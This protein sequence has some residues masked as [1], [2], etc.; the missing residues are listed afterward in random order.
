MT[1]TLAWDGC[2]NV[3]D[4]GGL[5]LGDSGETAYRVVVRS[6]SVRTL[7]DAGWEA[8]AGYGV[9]RIL[10]LRWPAELARDPARDLDVEVVHVSLFGADRDGSYADKYDAY[11][12]ASADPVDYYRW[13]YLEVLDE[14]RPGFATALTA[15]ADADGTAVVHCTGGKDRTGL[16]CALALRLAGVSAAE[17]VADWALSE[18]VWVERDAAWVAAAPDER[19]RKRRRTF[20]LAPAQ[21]MADVLAELERRHGGARAY[22]EDAGVEPA[23]LDRLAARLRGATS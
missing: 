7:S 21:A 15:L 10:D 9:R 18:A 23:A 5:P 8:L 4:L 3:R 19:E 13:S 17:V 1:R 22:L 2:H 11:L 16:V 14:F 12:L 20:G 6:D